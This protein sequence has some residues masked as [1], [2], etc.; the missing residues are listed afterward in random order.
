M[1]K[2][3]WAQYADCEDVIVA[4]FEAVLYA[5]G[6]G[7]FDLHVQ[8]FDSDGLEVWP[9]TSEAAEKCRGVM[10]DPALGGLLPFRGLRV[11]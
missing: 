5:N 3:L 2:S 8:V 6:D 7:T 10:A 11:Q 9:L 4:A 1:S